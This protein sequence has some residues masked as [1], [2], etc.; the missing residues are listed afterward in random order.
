MYMNKTKA[1]TTF[2]KGI[3]PKFFKIFTEPVRLEI[4]RYLMIEGKSDIKS[5][6]ESF[7]QDRSVISRHLQFM[8]EGKIIQSEKKGRHLYYFVDADSFLNVFKTLSDSAH[9]CI[10][11]CC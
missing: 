1:A 6:A 5:I 3:D 10:K 9:C 8:E 7:P 4:L 2:I 11:S